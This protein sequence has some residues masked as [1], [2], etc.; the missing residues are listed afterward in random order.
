MEI[1]FLGATGTVTGSKYLFDDGDAINLVDCG[2]FQ[3][4][5][6][7]RLRNWQPLPI[8]PRRIGSV[9]L[10]HAHIDH[11]GYLPLLVKNGFSGRIYCSKATRELCQILLPDS[12][13]LQE[14]EARYANKRGFSKHKPALPLYTIE[15][16]DRALKNFHAVDFD[17]PLRL[18]PATSA[19]LLPAGHI[20]GASMVMIESRG[21]QILFS[22]DLGRPNDPIMRPP[23]TVKSA[24][25]LV[26]EST[27]GNRRHRAGSPEDELGSHLK[28]TLDRGGV[29]VIPAFAVGR[30]QTLL[31]LMAR[32]KARGMLTNVPI[33]LNSPMAVDAT[34]IY[35]AYRSE[36][37]LTVEECTA[38][39]QIAEFVNS[40]EASKELN[41]K[42]GPMIIISAS[43]M[44]TGGRVLHHLKAFAP[45]PK[46][47]I[48]FS[49]FQAGG[50]RGAALVGGA[51]SVKIHGQY[52]PVR[53]EVANL[54]GLS[55]HADYVEILDWLRAFR[56]APNKIC[57][58]HGEPAAADA[59]RLH[60]QESLGWQ[61]RVPDYLEKMTVK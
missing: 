39:C 34:R 22:G 2:L 50:T 54:E 3:G 15:D 17:E 60:I 38:A 6:Q 23:V 12:A 32:L 58:T 9:V 4:F 18:S 5:K 13:H 20:L 57:I 61:S 59:M 26:L 8:D 55:G 49:G 48:L 24:D 28:R 47:M 53:A 33:Y 19:R 45:D 36:H 41:A 1:T 7:L 43:G 42:R 51:D 29:V 56:R 30:A 25:V 14:E 52:V 35:H 11:S 40:P 44:A 27:Y 31:H 37:R 16:A 10:T 46:N 21:K